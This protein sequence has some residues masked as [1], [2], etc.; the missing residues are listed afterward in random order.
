MPFE[1]K[2]G[3]GQSVSPESFFPD[4]DA[5]NQPTQT[6]PEDASLN[7]EEQTAP[8]EFDGTQWKFK[9][10]GKEYVP[11]TKEE[12]IKWASLG[13]NY[14][15]KARKLNEDRAKFL[16]EKAGTAQTQTP[17]T[18]PTAKEPQ[19]LIAPNPFMDPDVAKLMEQF[20][21]LSQELADV[22]SKA[23]S[24][25]QVTSSMTQTQYDTWLDESLTSLKTELGDGFTPDMEQE[26]CMDLT[27]M[28]ESVP[29]E[30]LKTKDG[31]AN[32]IRSAYFI[33][34]PEGIEAAVQA[35]VKSGLNQNKL[36]NGGKVITE[37]TALGAAKRNDIPKNWE[38]AD[39]RALNMFRGM[40]DI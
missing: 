16:Q 32:L 8:A 22:R 23:E 40:K 25:D 7:T 6:Q 14:D 38:D 29:D 13:I 17:Q 39:E 15:V 28:M 27:E 33:R 37:G 24:A 3:D 36:Q 1:D 21:T 5:E 2:I 9:A 26:L 31:V 30:R 11:K 18:P 35:R 4:E 12:L 10:A 34:H 20:Q 19:A